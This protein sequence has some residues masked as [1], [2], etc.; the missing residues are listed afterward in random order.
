MQTGLAR[1]KSMDDNEADAD[2]RPP[3]VV[4]PTKQGNSSGWSTH[5]FNIPDIHQDISGQQCKGLPDFTMPPPPIV[6]QTPSS[7]CND[8]EENTILKVMEKMTETMNQQMKL[9]AT[10]ADYNMQQNTKMMDQFIRAQDRRD[11]DPA[12]MNIPTFTGQE[13]GRCLEWIT[14][15]RN[16]CRQSGRP[17]QQELTNKAGLVVQN[18]LSSLD[19][20]ITENELVEKVLQMFSDIPTTTQAIKKL[21]EMRQAE[22]ESIL[23]FNQRYKTLVERVE[24]RPIEL[25]TSPVAMEMYLGTI[26]PPLRKSIK[27]SIFWG[28][29]HAP[30]TV[31]EAMTKAQQL[32]VKHLYAVGKE[33]EEEHSKPVEDVVINEISQKFQNRYQGRRDDFRDSSRN[34]RDH[35]DQGQE[36]WQQYGGTKNSNYSPRYQ[37]PP[38]TTEVEDQSKQRRFD[39]PTVQASN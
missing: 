36:Q 23:V 24:G 1:V 32:Y 10:R 12:L 8:P 21:K 26:I 31:G 13:P 16:V 20:N 9:S 6:T 11:L 29:K 37:S 28:S 15:I 5:S 18:F 17:L 27:N 34:R 38:T 30:N 25:I 22:N 4:E 33:T 14:R 39:T 7:R 3:V 19:P 35:Y 2:V